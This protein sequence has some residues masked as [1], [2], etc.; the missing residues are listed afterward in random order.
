MRQYIDAAFTMVAAEISSPII[1][2]CFLT[3]F[4]FYKTN[5]KS[6]YIIWL[7]LNHPR[8]SVNYTNT[9]LSV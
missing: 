7:L 4:A 6:T 3:L 2:E 1:P 9:D 8:D 5:S